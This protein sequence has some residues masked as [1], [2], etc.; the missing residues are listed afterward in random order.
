MRKFTFGLFQ[1]SFRSG[2]TFR[3]ARRGANCEYIPL[4]I[5][6]EELPA[7]PEGHFIPD[8]SFIHIPKEDIMALVDSLMECLEMAGLRQNSQATMQELKATKF[9]LEDMRK[10]V[11]K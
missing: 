1:E 2:W 6:I 7:I 5:T 4:K 9:H 3:A 10:L 8:E 11:F